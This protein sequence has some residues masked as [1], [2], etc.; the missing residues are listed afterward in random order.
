M[1][2]AFPYIGYHTFALKDFL[3]ALGAEVCLPPPLTK[4]TLELG[5]KYSPEMVCLPF[6]I[7]LGNFIEALEK[8]ADTLFMA[9]GARKCRFGYYHYLQER[10][11][12]ELGYQFRFY[13]VSQYSPYEF[14]FEKMPQIFAV[15]PT[16]VLKALYLMIKKS[17][18]CENFKNCLRVIRAI[19][20]QRSLEFEKEYLKK[21]ENAK[22]I[23]EIN[24]LNKELKR[25]RKNW[26]KENRIKLKVGLVGEIY[27]LLEDFANQ[28]LEKEL[29]K[30]GVLVLSKRSLYSRLKHLLKIEKEFLKIYYYAKKYLAVSP[31]GEAIHTIGETI[32]FIKKGVDGIIHI[33]PFTCMPENI[34]LHSL[35]KISEDYNIPILSL[36]F[37]EHTSKTGILTRVEAFLELLK[38][39]K[40]NGNSIYWN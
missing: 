14:I 8:G 28:E 22:R 35:E 4:R 37:D 7:T 9:A 31:G 17:E 5:A 19:D 1:K 29:G 23:K 16:Q 24:I 38:R 34:V 21:I 10:I 32:D 25:I 3:T 18:L 36:S 26:L 39:R 2:A 6:K 30:L 40:R 15:S 20:Y 33:F 12:K 27:F 11:L 13:P